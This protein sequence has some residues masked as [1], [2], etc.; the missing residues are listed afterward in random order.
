MESFP[1][2]DGA[3]IVLAIARRIVENR[4][5]LSDIDGLIGDGDHGVNMAKGFSLTTERLRG[6]PRLS[7]IRSRRSATC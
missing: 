5:Y 2:A 3:G 6:E 1:N 4:A 7:Q